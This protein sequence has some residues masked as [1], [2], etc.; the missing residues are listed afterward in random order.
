MLRIV[1]ASSSTVQVMLLCRPACTA[2]LMMSDDSFR[3]PVH[4]LQMAIAQFQCN[5]R[6]GKITLNHAHNRCIVLCS[7]FGIAFTITLNHLGRTLSFLLRL[8]FCAFTITL[9]HLGRALSFFLRLLSA[10]L[11]SCSTT[12]A[13]RSTEV[14]R[15]RS[16][17]SLSTS[18]FAVCASVAIPIASKAAEDAS[19]AANTA[20]GIR[21]TSGNCILCYRFYSLLFQQ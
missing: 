1:A 5:L 9:N 2:G 10:R 13:A 3:Y 11:R 12:L 15:A 18:S 7:P 14:I 4:L 6:V 20:T 8:L 21:R 19:S 16:S 17:R